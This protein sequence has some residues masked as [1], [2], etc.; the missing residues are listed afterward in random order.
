MDISKVWQDFGRNTETGKL[1]YQLYGQK[2]R[3][4]ISVPVPKKRKQPQKQEEKP[5]TSQFKE[6]IAK[7]DYPE[8]QKKPTNTFAKVDLIPKRKSQVEIESELEK[9]KAIQRQIPKVAPKNR[10]AEIGFCLNRKAA[11]LLRIR[12]KHNFP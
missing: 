1:L 3:P 9:I 2:F 7:I 5:K 8:V 11:R 10:V 12:E 6:R 4:T